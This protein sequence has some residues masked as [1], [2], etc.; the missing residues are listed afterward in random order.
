MQLGFLGFG[1]MGSRMVTKLVSE[2]HDVIGWN[3]SPQA[4]EDLKSQI[5][6][7]HRKA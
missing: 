4:V 2:G 5:S 1:K 7:P 6:N 3:R